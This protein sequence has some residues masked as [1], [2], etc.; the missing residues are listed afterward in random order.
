MMKSSEIEGAGS[1]R[2]VIE[3]EHA[4]SLN[5][6]FSQAIGSGRLVFVAGQIG[7]DPATGKL[8]GDD[9]RTQTHQALKNVSAIL[10]AAGTSVRYVVRSGCFLS[11]PSHFA[12]FNEVYREY[13]PEDPP[14]RTTVS[15]RFPP[16]ILV[17]VDVIAVV[18][19]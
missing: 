8:A 18:P 3:T 1:M 13:F 19:E 9:I 4:P 16:G 5:L 10:E 15:V 11:D 12:D 14:A 7:Q 17:E 6:P 2:R